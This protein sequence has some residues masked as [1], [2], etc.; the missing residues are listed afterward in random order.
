MK[1]Q[2]AFGEVTHAL[3]REHNPTSPGYP[4]ARLYPAKLMVETNR[5]IEHLFFRFFW[6]GVVFIPA[7]P[8]TARYSPL[9]FH[10]GRDCF[11]FIQVSNQTLLGSVHF[12]NL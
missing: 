3:T 2:Q 12:V 7:P 6:G 5:S 1:G 8:V 9:S 10:T 4:G 11:I